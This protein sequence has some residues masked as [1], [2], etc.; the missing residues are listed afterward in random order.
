MSTRNRACPTVLTVN[1]FAKVN[2]GLKLLR[3]RADG[4]HELRTVFQTIDLCDRLTFCLR[5]DHRIVLE[6]NDPRLPVNSENL[7]LR[8]ARLALAH[9][10]PRRGVSIFLEKNIPVGAG[11]GGGSS[12]AATTLL[13]LNQLFKLD[14]KPNQLAALA[15]SLGSDVSFFLIGGRAF[16]RGRGDLLHPLPDL[17]PVALLVACPGVR[18]ATRDAYRK[19]SLWLTKNHPPH[20]MARFDLE[21]FERESAF[22]L[23]ENDFENVLFPKYPELRRLKSSL[24]AGGARSAQ[25]T[26]SGSAVFGVYPSQLAARRAEKK[27]QSSPSISRLST[28][29]ARSLPR[30]QYLKRIFAASP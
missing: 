16:G 2:L 9:A 17:K 1:S 10:R 12:N 7:A 22:R 11:L 4:F 20:N 29:V 3:R 5:Q 18:I 28:F 8:A 21:V 24:L 14:L 30:F 25:M 27:L 23:F 26:G 6:C 19:A 13:T 15:A